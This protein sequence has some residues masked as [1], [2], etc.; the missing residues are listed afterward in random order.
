MYPCPT[1]GSRSTVV[2]SRGWERVS[3]KRRRGCT[4]CNRRWTTI[5]V[6][7]TG[8]LSSIEGKL[9]ALLA[10]F[11][12]GD[13]RQCQHL[14]PM[15]GELLEL[16]TKMRDIEKRL[17]DQFDTEYAPSSDYI[18]WEREFDEIIEQNYGSMSCATLAEVMAEQFNV[19]F[20]ARKVSARAFHLGLAK[21]R[22]KKETH[23]NVRI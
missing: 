22:E 14:E 1:C 2:D 20:T 16:I 9:E 7:I 11:T 13:A 10:I 3:V 8:A 6:N 21:E 4:E 18:R 19:P 23:E 17:S 5:E 15:E 12:N